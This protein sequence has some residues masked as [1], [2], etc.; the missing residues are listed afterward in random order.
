MGRRR[1]RFGLDGGRRGRQAFEAVVDAFECLVEA[2]GGHRLALERPPRSVD[3]TADARHEP[4]RFRACLHDGRL[5]VAPGAGA[6]FLGV[7]QRLDGPCLGQAGAFERVGGLALGLPDRG[8]GRLEVPLRLG[9]PR[10]GVGHDLLGQAEPLGDR[11]RLAPAGQADR[12]AIGRR[13]RLEI[14]LDRRVACP[15]GRVG[16]RL[17]LGVVG[18]GCDER[19]GPDEVVEECLGQGGTL[20]RVRAGA[21][22]VEQDERP[23]PGGPH[24]RVDPLE[25][26]AERREALSDRLLVPDVGEHVAEDRQLAAALGGDLQPG[27]VHEREQAERAQRH[28]LAAGVGPG[29]DERGV[30]VAEPDVDG[31]DAC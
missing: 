16:V 26:A 30:A 4:L 20:G 9:Q 23:G 7:A 6:L 22:L 29:D 17:Q 8:Q 28:G 13:E 25:V 24:D 31:H 12:Q 19:A 3:L 1:R 11:E 2:L 27:L 18:R 10:A 21:Q 14:E 15:V 5:A